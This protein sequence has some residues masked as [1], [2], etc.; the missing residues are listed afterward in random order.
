MTDSKEDAV[1]GDNVNFYV[2]NPSTPVQFFHLLRRQ[3]LLHNSVSVLF[4]DCCDSIDLY[5][6]R[7]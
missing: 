1:D 2:T 6:D 5:L 7:S 3:V 4:Y